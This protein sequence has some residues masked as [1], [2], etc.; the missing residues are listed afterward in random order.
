M[1]G[2]CSFSPLFCTQINYIFWAVFLFGF[3]FCKYHQV[4]YDRRVRFVHFYFSVIWKLISIFLFCFS[5]FFLL[6]ANCFSIAWYSIIFMVWF[7]FY[8]YYPNWLE[9]HVFFAVIFSSSF[10]SCARRQTVLLCLRLSNRNVKIERLTSCSSPFQVNRFDLSKKI[11]I[12][13]GNDDNWYTIN[14]E[15]YVFVRGTKYSRLFVSKENKM[16][17]NHLDN[18][19]K[20]VQI[21]FLMK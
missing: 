4:A 19:E 1:Y 14:C 18:N 12:F 5:L 2:I 9:N 20:I 10:W 11:V 3:W 16:K 13:I 8:F 17:I 21:F 7:S 6:C 15:I